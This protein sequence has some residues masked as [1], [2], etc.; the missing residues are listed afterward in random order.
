M[1]SI[2]ITAPEPRPD[3]RLVITF[4]WRDGQNVDSDGDSIPASSRDWTELY[5]ANRETTEP[6]VSVSP[7][8]ESPL[9]L[10]IE[11][12]QATLAARVAY[13][14]ASSTNGQVAFP[15][16]QP[17]SPPS[18][19]VPYL[20]DDFDPDEAFL[21]VAR[22]SLNQATLDNPYPNLTPTI[23]QRIKKALGL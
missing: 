13:F 6:S 17:V 7:E 23:S 22:S 12:A 5:L 15:P 10:R 2:C 8:Q 4:L 3:F 11:S 9:V 18:M 16:E 14:L 21:R 20:G 1:T 19:L